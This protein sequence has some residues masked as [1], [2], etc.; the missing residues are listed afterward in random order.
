MMKS[1]MS[2]ESKYVEYKVTYSKTFLK[3]VSAYANYHSGTIVFGINDDGEVIGV[4]KVD[5]LKLSIEHAIHDAI[6][7]VPYYDINVAEEDGKTLVL[8]NVYKGE[9]TP[10]NYSGKPYQRKDTSS[11]QVDRISHRELI[12]N[13]QNM[14]FDELEYRDDNLSFAFLRSR[15]KQFMG[16]DNLTDDLLRTLELKKISN[17]VNAAALLSDFNPIKS[18]VINMIAYKDDT[19]REIIDR[20]VLETISLV[21][22][23][24][25][26]LR[27]YRKHINTSEKIQG[28]YRETV[29]EVP[30]VAY[31]EAITNAIIHRDYLRG[32]AIRIQVFSNRIEI[33]SPGSLPIG[34]SVDEYE[35]GNISI[36]RNRII[37]DVFR[38]LGI[39]EKFGTGIQRIKEYYRD[40]SEQPKFMVYDN[41][42]TVVLPRNTEV[43]RVSQK[44][45]KVVANMTERE[46]R[47]YL[48][49]Q[50]KESVTRAEI[51]QVLQLK[52]SQ[53]GELLKS[54]K[55][56]DVILMIGSGRNT[57]YT[58]KG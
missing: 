35:I 5:S 34:L 48:L 6:D 40:L 26:C 52:R 3:T 32:A 16:I 37:A 28:P 51:E 38:R 47:V 42:V 2:G 46:Q 44:T 31:R 15:L 39:V 20:E 36:V 49:L 9:H 22:Q 18:S 24:E 11:V 56:K 7:P 30:L 41:S 57:K 8:L 58:L 19:V 4:D 43:S 50:E 17:F 23:Y 12:L 1:M 45:T 27:F 14:G 25:A 13:G 21:E 33:V 53:S 54:M 10:Y 29:E 55:E